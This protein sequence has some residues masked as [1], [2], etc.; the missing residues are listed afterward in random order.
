MYLGLSLAFLAWAVFLSNPLALLF[1]PVYVLYINRF[2][3]IPEERV[4]GSLFATAI[5]S[6]LVILYITFRSKYR[7]CRA[8][9]GDLHW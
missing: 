4:L 6:A 1:W 2:Q 3:I 8:K 9:C 5:Q 7:F